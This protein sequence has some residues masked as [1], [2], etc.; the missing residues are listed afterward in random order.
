MS[1]YSNY[2]TSTKT[3]TY[4]PTGT[5]SAN[6]IPNEIT[7]PVVQPDIFFTQGPIYGTS[8]AVIG[9]PVSGGAPVTLTPLLDFTWSPLYL[10]ASENTGK[11][12][13][14]FILLNNY[15][16][17]SSI[18]CTYQAVGGDV[19]TTLLA[20]ITVLG[21]FDK[22]NINIWLGIKGQTNI[23]LGTGYTPNGNNNWLTSFTD[24]LT[25]LANAVSIPNSLVKFISYNIINLT[26]TVTSNYTSLT[27]SISSLSTTVSSNY[28]SLTAS[29]SSLSTTVSSNYTSLSNLITAISA[30][31]LNIENVNGIVVSNGSGVFSAATITVIRSLISLYLQPSGTV[32]AFAGL[33]A[34][35]GY[36][37]C[38]NTPTYWLASLYSDLY[39][40][41]GSTWGTMTD[42]AGLH[43]GI[44]YFPIG[45][46][47]LAGD[48]GIL[49]GINVGNITVGQVI[50]HTHLAP[51][52]SSG[53]LTSGN[54][55]N[56][57]GG[58]AN[59]GAATTGTPVYPLL[60]SGTA[61]NLAA[62]TYLL[63]CIKL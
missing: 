60:A 27:T 15:A 59:G 10:S 32:I 26:N 22:T 1:N 12:V 40:A 53:Y 45:Y 14:S 55:L 35:P 2:S 37:V 4:D 30:I 54:G 7:S 31:V 13:Y 25:N 17:W 39:T 49:S 51:A 43:F 23:G 52:G 44:P 41:L 48:T 33:T 38:P 50:S 42:S 24:R 61:F 5:N 58:G 57:A 46:A 6:L 8:L 20:N 9:I 47:A 3:V 36:M 34:P 16:L 29:I 19:D 18:S 63:M 62:G 11:V 56:F 28:T 21:N